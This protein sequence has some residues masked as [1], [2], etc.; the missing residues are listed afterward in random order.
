MQVVKT[1]TQQQRLGRKLWVELLMQN[2][3]SRDVTD[4]SLPAVVRRDS[5]SLL[6][7]SLVKSK[8]LAEALGLDERPRDELQSLASLMA[9]GV[10]VRL[11]VD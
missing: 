1:E 2:S 4:E 10:V 8:L 5:L 7:H 6:W 11:T 9:N 3:L